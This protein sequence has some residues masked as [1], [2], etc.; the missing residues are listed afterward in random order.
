ALRRL[1]AASEGAV[2][3]VLDVNDLRRCLE[4]G[5]LAMILHFEDASAIDPGFN[6]LEVFYAAGMRSLGL[7]WSRPNLYATG[8]PFRFPA[9]PD[10]G[11]G[12]TDLGK[13]LVSECNRMGIMVDL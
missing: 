2:S 13:A 10:I 9:G 8:V 3:I 7:C 5:S 6:A 12:L 1:A 11:P 4:T